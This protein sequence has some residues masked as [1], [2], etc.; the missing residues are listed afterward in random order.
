MP[1]MYVSDKPTKKKKNPPS[2]L[3]HTDELKR[4]KFN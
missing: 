3:G 1:Y 4:R 2:F